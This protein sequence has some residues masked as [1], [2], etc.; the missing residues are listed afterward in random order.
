MAESINLCKSILVKNCYCWF[1]SVNLF[2]NSSV[3]GVELLRIGTIPFHI[4]DTVRG[5]QS[6]SI[7]LTESCPDLFQKRMNRRT[8]KIP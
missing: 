2:C 6:R 1:P 3:E 7:V 5:S 4:N 8:T